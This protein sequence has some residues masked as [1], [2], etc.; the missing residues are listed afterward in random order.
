[1]RAQSLFEVV[2][3]WALYF[4]NKLSRTNH[5]KTVTDMRLW[6]QFV[7]FEFHIFT[8]EDQQNKPRLLFSCRLHG[9]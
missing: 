5:F 8:N 2:L 7:R 4:G 1:M 3:F 6:V 9:K